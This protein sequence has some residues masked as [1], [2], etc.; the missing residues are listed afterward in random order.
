MTGLALPAPSGSSATSPLLGR[1]RT[2]LSRFP[3]HLDAER[4][5]KQLHV[6]A[7]AMASGLDDLSA[8][9][10][11]IRRAHRLG[12]ADATTDLLL[13]GALHRI[14]SAELGPLD[15]RLDGIRSATDALQGALDA[16]DDAA[17]DAAGDVLT[18]L[19]GIEGASPRLTLFAP[20]PAEGAPVTPPDLAAAASAL[21]DAA[22]R[23]TSYAG[24]REAIRARIAGLCALHVRG[25]GTVRA[26]LEGA[27]AG[28]RPGD[29]RG[30]RRRVQTIAPSGRGCCN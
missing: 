8:S 22:R 20:P 3:A 9:L 10:A 6:V 21:V 26:L 28:A 1:A 12:H 4:P 24:R 18:A 14:G 11:A 19:L 7:N 13:L 17:R 27:A 16:S 2:V 30:A 15:A 29:R 25:N 23:L 5:G